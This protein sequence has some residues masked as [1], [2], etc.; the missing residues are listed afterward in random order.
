MQHARERLREERRRSVLRDQ[1]I[2]WRL[3]AEIRAYC[4]ALRSQPAA[5]DEPGRQAWIAWAEH[6]ADSIDPLRR[7]TL[8]PADPEPSPSALQ[9]FLP[10]GFSAYGP[11]LYG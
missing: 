1:L 7:S 4:A 9:P 8:R 6:H 10:S 3:A 11:S 5:S 2:D